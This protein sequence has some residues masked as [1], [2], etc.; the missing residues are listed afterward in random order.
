MIFVHISLVPFISSISSDAVT[1]GIGNT[2]GNKGGV[3]IRMS[4]GNTNFMFVN[5]HLAAHQNAIQ[6]RN[7]NIMRIEKELLHAHNNNDNVFKIDK[8]TV[9][10]DLVANNHD[11]NIVANPTSASNTVDTVDKAIN[12]N[13]NILS[14]AADVVLFMGDMNYRIKGNRYVYNT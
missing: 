7:N 2:L 14:Q 8:S 9:E 5:V 6:E 11:H 10:H 3:C 1:T 12:S 13:S 4:V